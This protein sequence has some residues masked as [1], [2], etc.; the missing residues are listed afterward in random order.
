MQGWLSGNL[1][2]F[3]GM[4]NE[5]RYTS[6]QETEIPGVLLSEKQSG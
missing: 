6:N 2:D 4:H 3:P 5:G 1:A